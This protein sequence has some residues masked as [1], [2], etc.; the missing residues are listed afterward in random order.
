MTADGSGGSWLASGR[1]TLSP[2]AAFNGTGLDWR[3]ETSTT[4]PAILCWVNPIDLTNARA[5]RLSVQSWLSPGASLG[6][7]QVSSDGV[8]WQTVATAPGTS[9]WTRIET[10]VSAFVGRMIHVRFVL[11]HIR[12][13]DGTAPD[14]WMVSDV[15]MEIIPWT[16]VSVA[17]IC[18]HCGTTLGTGETR[19]SHTGN[20]TIHRSHP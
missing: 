10:D 4:A 9:N 17:N 18:P 16:G 7:V 20:R 6:A 5:A 19:A 12:P 14:V 11:H 8:T 13:A 3:A 1:F 15:S 2:E